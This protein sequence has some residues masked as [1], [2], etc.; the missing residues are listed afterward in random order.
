MRCMWTRRGAYRLKISKHE[1]TKT[2]RH[3]ETPQLTILDGVSLCL[4]VF[5]SSCLLRDFQFR[6]LRDHLFQPIRNEADGEF[7]VVSGALG[8]KNSAVA[9]FGMFNPGAERPRAGGLSLGLD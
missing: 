1:D 5:V 7:H 9:V 8:A 4:C 2:Q 6:I 3:K